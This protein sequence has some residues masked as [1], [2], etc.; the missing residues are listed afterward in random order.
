VK[1]GSL[2]S[3][4]PQCSR[5][6]WNAG[7]FYLPHGETWH[8]MVRREAYRGGRLWRLVLVAVMVMATAEAAKGRLAA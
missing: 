1:R 8:I 2:A 5:P 6:R 4:C 7:N 3:L